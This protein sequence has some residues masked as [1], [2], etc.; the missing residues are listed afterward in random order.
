MA[1][2]GGGVDDGGPEATA[3]IAMAFDDDDLDDDG[4]TQGAGLVMDK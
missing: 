1:D 2:H 3:T 4:I